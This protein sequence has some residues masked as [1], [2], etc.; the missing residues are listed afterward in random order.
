MARN[1]PSKDIQ[2]V[3]PHEASHFQEVERWVEDFFRE[4][5]S[6]HRPS[7]WPR[8][9][10]G[11]WQGLSPSVDILED[12]K[13][14]VVRAEIPG[15]TKE[16]LNVTLEDG[17]LTISGETKEEKE[18]KKKQIYRSERSYG[19][20]TRSFRLPEALDQ[21]KVKAQF[22]DGILEIRVPKTAEEKKKG[23]A[24]RVE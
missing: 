22:K 4:P 8:P 1:A 10:A 13:D 23:M 16:D 7:W 12:E 6:M 24:I 2:L 3:E 20:F 9:W 21:D 11:Q 19:S 18:T 15:V 5:L 17:V 14:I